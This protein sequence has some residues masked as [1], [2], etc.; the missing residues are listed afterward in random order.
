MS[1]EK[2]SALDQLQYSVRITA[3][4]KNNAATRLEKFKNISFAITVLASL[5]LIFIPLWVIVFPID[6][7]KP[8]FKSIVEISQIF[9][10]IVILIFS[11]QTSNASYELKINK[12]R[13]CGSKLRNLSKTLRILEEDLKDNTELA[14]SKELRMYQQEYE[15]IL[16]DSEPHQDIDFLMTECE[17]DSFGKKLE[18][19]Y[20]YKKYLSLHFLYLYLSLMIIIFELVLILN[21]IGVN[22]ILRDINF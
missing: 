22:N 20:Y 18:K 2:T 19:G 5:G 12:L 9:L 3:N 6:L 1:K 11:I 7:N 8:V 21:L 16:S 10:A 15:K 13:V 17:K 14:K 4:C